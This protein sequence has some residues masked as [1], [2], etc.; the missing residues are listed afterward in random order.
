MILIL[1]KEGFVSLI[2]DSNDARILRVRFT[3]N[4]QD[5]LL[6]REKKESE[7][8]LKLFEEFNSSEIELLVK[9][10]SKL[11]K[12]ISQMESLYNYEEEE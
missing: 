4:C 2:K 12:N 11:G 6:Q 8:L 3:K 9:S 1:E 10:I 7:F 5:Y